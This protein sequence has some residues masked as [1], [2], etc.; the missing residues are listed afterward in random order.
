MQLLGTHFLKK[1]D[2]AGVERRIRMARFKHLKK[3]GGIKRK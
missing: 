2:S 1:E 3:T